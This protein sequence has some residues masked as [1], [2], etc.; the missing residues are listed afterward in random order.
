MIKTAAQDFAIKGHP[1]PRGLVLSQVLAVG[2][3]SRFE[4]LRRGALNNRTDGR[5]CGQPL[6]VQLTPLIQR[7]VMNSDESLNLTIGRRTTQNRQHG[8]EQNGPQL[9]TPTLPTTMIGDLAQE[10]QQHQ[11][12][13]ADSLRVTQLSYNGLYKVPPG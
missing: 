8:R 3:K 13:S 9:V 1:A 6:P 5:L 4:F 2:S 7:G 12:T 10:L 11:V